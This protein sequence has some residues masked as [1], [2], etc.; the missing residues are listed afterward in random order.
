GVRKRL[1]E[2]VPSL[3][4]ALKYAKVYSELVNNSGNPLKVDLKM[5]ED[6]IKEVY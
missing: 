2:F 5:A 4:D 1:S 6:F 3:E